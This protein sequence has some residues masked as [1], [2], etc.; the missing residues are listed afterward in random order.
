MKR[1][2]RDDNNRGRAYLKSNNISKY[3]YNNNSNNNTNNKLLTNNTITTTTNNNNNKNSI[4]IDG[5]NDRYCNYRN[6]ITPN[7]TNLATIYPDFALA[8]TNLKKR[9]RKTKEQQSQSSSSSTSRYCFSTNI[10]HSFNIAL[11]R[12]ILHQQFKLYMPF[13]PETNLVPPVPNR[14]H[15]VRWLKEL[16]C[17]ISCRVD[18]YFEKEDITA[19]KK[20]EDDVLYGFG[21][22]K[23]GG[24]SRGLNYR[25]LDLGVGASAIYPLL[26]STRS[27]TSHDDCCCGINN[28]GIISCRSN[29]NV[30]NVA[31][32]I[33]NN[34]NDNNDKWTFVG[35]DI[36]PES[37]SCAKRNVNANDGLERKIQILLVKPSQ[38]QQLES[39]REEEEH[40]MKK[41]QEPRGAVKD[42]TVYQLETKLTGSCDND[43]VDGN[44]ISC[45]NIGENFES[46]EGNVG[47]QS[48]IDNIDNGNNRGNGGP[49]QRA[50]E[51]YDNSNNNNKTNAR[52]DFCMTNP[53]FYGYFNEANNPRFGDG[54]KRTEM[55]LSES[56]YPNNGEQGFVY[57]MI[58][59]S[60]FYKNRI[61]W[62]TSLL[63]RKCSLTKMEGILKDELGLWKGSMRRVETK[64]GG[65]GTNTGGDNGRGNN[66]NVRWCLAW[67]F[68]RVCI[69]SPGEFLNSLFWDELCTCIYMNVVISVFFLL[70][71]LIFIRAR[72]KPSFLLIQPVLSH[73]S[74]FFF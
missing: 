52:F 43:N 57:D 61:T 10:D 1:R 59:D 66:V 33:T 67:S 19:N 23:D 64:Q 30:T 54:R 39:Q 46:N 5:T 28:S 12:S 31:S 35:T 40:E 68:R 62:Y 32:N 44:D 60:L 3:H 2:R 18:D 47:K 15:Y 36:D 48:S 22:R 65:R 38:T 8:F 9:Q 70:D 63:G 6:L 7:F 17:Q 56:T 27:F 21:E 34:T 42:G 37:I 26:L 41:E 16:I 14:Y 74:S 71:I 49:I 45:A 53:P 73:L 20:E 58:K 69:R 51:A 4:I 11:T 29:N 24:G 72:E 13:L 55:T 25:G 50:L